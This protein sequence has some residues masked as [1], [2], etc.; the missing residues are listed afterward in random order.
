MVALGGMRRQIGREERPVLAEHR[1][2]LNR[3]R[4]MVE[5]RH[6]VPQPLQ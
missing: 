3:F 5:T 6:L 4:V 1:D 2:V